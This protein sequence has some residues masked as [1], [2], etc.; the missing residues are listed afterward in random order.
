MNR[1]GKNREK[2]C[3]FC[4]LILQNICFTSVIRTE[5][6]VISHLKLIEEDVFVLH[7]YSTMF[8]HHGYVVW[9]CNYLINVYGGGSSVMSTSYVLKYL[10][11][12]YK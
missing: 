10:F 7:L 12:K 4:I 8:I 5:E 11:N 1:G 2:E 6:T 3:S 9:L